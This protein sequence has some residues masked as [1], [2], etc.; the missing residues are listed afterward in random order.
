MTLSDNV[1]IG[2]L[3]GGLVALFIVGQ[4]ICVVWANFSYVISDGYLKM[5]WRILRYV[6]VPFYAWSINLSEISDVRRR[7]PARDTLWTFPWRGIA[8][9]GNLTLT[10]GLIITLKRRFQ[11]IY[12]HVYV[13]PANPD[14]FMQRLK[15]AIAEYEEQERGGKS[16]HDR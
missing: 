15:T 3:I 9:Y 5:R 12:K 14:E 2:L 8:V 10:R 11:F 4:C 6:P 1:T 16:D 13:N 7:D